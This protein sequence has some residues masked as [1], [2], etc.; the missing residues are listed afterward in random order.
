MLNMAADY[1]QGPV[2]SALY[3]NQDMT[4]EKCGITELEQLPWS[5]CHCQRESPLISSG[6]MTKEW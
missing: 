4:L 2:E 3:H 6:E 5:N 1:I